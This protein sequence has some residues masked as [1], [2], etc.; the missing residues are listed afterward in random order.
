MIKRIIYILILIIIPANF[1]LAQIQSAGIEKSIYGYQFNPQDAD[2]L[3]EKANNTM[4]LWEISAEKK[5]KEKY[6]HEAMNYYFLLSKVRKGSIEAEIGLGRIYDELKMDILAKQ[7][8]FNAYNINSAN[9]KMNY[10]FGNYYYKRNDLN[11]ALAYYKKAYSTGEINTYEFYYRIG[12]IYEK[13]AD[14]ETSSKFYQQAY[15]LNPKDTL[16]KRKIL[17]LEE[18]NYSQSQYYLYKGNQ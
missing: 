4:K 11:T 3:L 10:Y 6:L 13:L 9:A 1:A 18:L 5:I 2:D 17:L 16:L 14:I 7:H 8:F 12:T 15:R